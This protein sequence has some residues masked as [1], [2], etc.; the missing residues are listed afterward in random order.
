MSFLGEIKRR[1]VFQVAAVYA[2]VA[3]LLIQVVDVIGEP[4]TL[5]NWINAVV[6]VL[7]AVGF[8]IAVILAWAFD[9]T[10]EGIKAD[11]KTPG[12]SSSSR[13]AGHTLNYLLQGL[14]LVAVGF[15]VVDQ[16]VLERQDTNPARTASLENLAASDVR[17]FTIDIG[18]T[19]PKGGALLNADITLTP[20][21]KQ[22]VFSAQ[23]DD[24][25]HLYLRD[26]DQLEANPIPGTEVGQLPFISPDGDWIGYI[27]VGGVFKIPLRGGVA[28]LVTDQQTPGAGGVWLED[29][30]MI[31]TSP[32]APGNSLRR[33]GPEPGE[34]EFL[35]FADADPSLT[36]SQPHVL[37]GG[38]HL[39]ATSSPFES[40]RD[41][42]I[43]LSSL[44]TGETKILVQGGFNS[45]YVPTGHIVFMRSNDLWAIPFDLENKQINGSEVLVV[46]D[47]QVGGNR[48]QAVYDFTDDGLLIYLP[49]ADRQ[50]T[51]LSNSRILVWVDRDGRETPLDL[52]P[53][54]YRLPRLS[55]DG[56]R[57]AIDLATSTSRSDTWIY[58]FGRSTLSRLTF[59]A[60]WDEGAIWS[61][62]GKQIIYASYSDARGIFIRNS[63]GSGQRELLITAQNA[64]PE[65][66]SPDGQDLL[67]SDGPQ[68]G[69][70]TATWDGYVISID[71]DS[72][73]RSLLKTR[74]SETHFAISP[75]GNWLAYSSNESGRWEVYVRPYPDLDEGKW[76]VSIDGGGGPRWRADGRELFY[77]TSDAVMAVGVEAGEDFA[78]DVP[79]PSFTGEYYSP[80]IPGDF[81]FRH[82]DVTSDGHE[83]LMIKELDERTSESVSKRTSLIAVEN[84]FEELKRLAPANE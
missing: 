68:G 30:S 61:P 38:T 70:P 52:E 83:F 20:D 46:E 26:L 67:Y 1:K 35:N 53:G 72:S 37:P 54:N 8:P 17:R 62:D 19:R 81:A 78:F 12:K 28:E 40:A 2:V 34:S 33:F 69:G 14:V 57:L 32:R 27:G 5:P 9:L 11:S 55:P 58:D 84:W 71:D 15:L 77:W 60:S 56:S 48:G 16:Y 73:R 21:G 10:P 39:L 7:L 42:H 63:D 47:I 43:L 50:G 45:R 59:G 25:P 64:W 65:S 51:D 36:Y 80:G 22:L 75:N 74:F 24:V 82:W 23:R 3:W 31:I 29:G 13:P 49:G 44:E 41:G 79:V 6:I 4:L 66:L 18:M 76:Q